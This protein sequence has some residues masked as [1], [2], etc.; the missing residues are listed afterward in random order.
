MTAVGEI[1]RRQPCSKVLLGSAHHHPDSTKVCIDKAASIETVYAWM[2]STLAESGSSA[3]AGT[4][5]S[6]D[7]PARRD[8]IRRRSASA[9]RSPR[10][11]HRRPCCGVGDALDGRN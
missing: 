1:D 8:A 9:D 11:A 6:A 3:P 5:K 7:R 10:R 4:S 2:R